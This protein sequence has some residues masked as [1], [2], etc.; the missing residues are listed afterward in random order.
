MNMRKILKYSTQIGPFY[1]A[2]SDDGRYHPVFEDES[3]G[4][5]GSIA[6]AIDDLTGGHTFCSRDTSKLGIPDNVA[7]W[8]SLGK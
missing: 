7:D 3:L 2:Q 5:Y 4:S 8:Q 1:I 6:L